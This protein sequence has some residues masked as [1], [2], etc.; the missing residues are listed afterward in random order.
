MGDMGFEQQIRYIVEKTGMPEAG[1]R[2]TLMFSATF[3]KNIQKLAQDF[4]HEYIFLTVGIIGATTDDIT[5]QFEF[6]DEDNKVDLLLQH[7]RNTT[8]LILVFTATKQTADELEYVLSQN[9]YNA[10]S[11]HGDR[12]QRDRETA[13]KSF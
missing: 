3:P 1:S 11:I 6:C 2:S 10:L 9:H 8:G 12:S 13:L 5:Q 4:L 7:V